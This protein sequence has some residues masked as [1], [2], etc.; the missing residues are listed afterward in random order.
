M[1]PRVLLLL[2]LLMAGAAAAESLPGIQLYES[3]EY[4]AAARAFEEVLADPRQPAEDRWLARIYLAA[5]LQALGRVDET[6]QQLE[7]IAREH[8][9]RQVDAVRFPPELVALAE[10]IRERVEAERRQAEQEALRQR[11]EQEAAQVR[12]PTQPESSLRP[13]LLGLVEAGNRALL[14]GGGLA[15]SRG[16]LEGSAHVWI[17]SSPVFH[18]QG[19]LLLGDGRLRPHLGLRA[20]LVPGQGGYGAGVLAGGRIFL[21]A[22]L[23][24]LVDVGGD[25][26][27][28]GDGAHHRF[29]LTAQAG[30]GLELFRP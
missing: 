12:R 20:T 16:V 1:S 21:P 7:V 11:Q 27:L 6:R 19:G 29:A 26:F 10:A 23:V 14:F 2:G 9:D 18:L 17:S 4:E 13:E 8:P 24:G 28:V 25:Y 22:G 3:G 30:L 15:Y 5:S